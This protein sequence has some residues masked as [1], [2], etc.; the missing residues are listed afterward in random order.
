LPSGALPL[1]LDDHRKQAAV[2]FANVVAR[3]VV[4]TVTLLLMQVWRIYRNTSEKGRLSR[5][6]YFFIAAFHVCDTL[7]VPVSIRMSGPKAIVESP[8]QDITL[9]PC[10]HYCRALRASQL[11]KPGVAELAVCSA[12]TSFT[13]DSTHACG[14]HPGDHVE[15]SLTESM[16]SF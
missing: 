1:C 6:H 7:P 16:Q 13:E 11:G 8:G 14:T 10:W 3:R 2:V 12:A 9:Q 4:H 5:R 15:I